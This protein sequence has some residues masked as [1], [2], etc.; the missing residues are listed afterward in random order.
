VLE[1]QNQSLMTHSAR[2]DPRRAS[3]RTYLYSAARNLAFKHFRDLG[4]DVSLGDRNNANSPKSTEPLHALLAGELSAEIQKAIPHLA[5]LQR[6]VVILFEYE[7]QTLADVAA[8][9][10]ADVGTV[11]SRL[12]RA[13]ERL[14]RD[15]APYFNGGS[16]ASKQESGHEQ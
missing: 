3:L 15:L 5:P 8:I 4:G 12:R 13:R 7:D 10:G 14:R 6:E 9:V 16:G 1:V 2:F 11:K